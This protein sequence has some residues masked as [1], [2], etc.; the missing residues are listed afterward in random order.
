V[1]F[2]FLKC[3]GFGSC[4]GSG[5]IYYRQCCGLMP[6]WIKVS[7]LMPVWILPPNFTLVFTCICNKGIYCFSFLISVISIKILGILGSLLKS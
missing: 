3:Q 1:V 5:M 4:D 6:I 7:I 2:I